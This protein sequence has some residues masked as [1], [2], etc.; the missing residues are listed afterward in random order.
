MAQVEIRTIRPS[1]IAV[2]DGSAARHLDLVLVGGVL[3]LA[4]IG[5]AMIYS[6][7]NRS[8]AVEGEDPSLYLKRQALF[9]GLGLIGMVVAA[10]IHYRFYRIWAPFLYLGSVLLLILVQSP[11]GTTV[12]G[13]QRWF[14]FGPFQLSPSLFTRLTLV[15]ML[16]A[17]LSGVKGDLTLRHIVRAVTLT[18]IPLGLVFIQPDIGTSIILAFTMVAMLVVAG[19]KVR[20]LVILG[21]VAAV[22]IFGAF[23]LNIIKDYQVQR[24]ISFVD[25]QADSL[26]TGYNRQQAE[27]AIGSGGLV[28]T[29]YLKGSQTTLDFVPEQHTDFIFTVVGEEFGFAGAMVMLGLFGLVLWRILRIASTA[30]DPFGT[31]ICVGVAA[32]LAVQLLVNVGMTIGVMPITGIPLP[33]ISYGGS[34]LIADLVAIGIVQNVYLRRQA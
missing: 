18:L 26:A 4:G 1:Q 34:A 13:S 31:L 17:Y 19:A 24:L 10:A 14:Q 7:T 20:Y 16:A 29:G 22:A 15:L 33:F 5:I 21:A 30:R 25:P 12:S 6:A 2:R 9:L 28:G 3:A 8:L 32:F 27:I 23:Q 11:L